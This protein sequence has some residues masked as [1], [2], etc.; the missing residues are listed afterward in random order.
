MLLS[1]VQ[2]SSFVLSATAKKSDNR[3]VLP[4]SHVKITFFAVPTPTFA[5]VKL[6]KQL[7]LKV[8]MGT[9]ILPT[10]V[11]SSF[12]SLEASTDCLENDCQSSHPSLSQLKVISI[13]FIRTSGL[14]VAL[15][16]FLI[17]FIVITTPKTESSVKNAITELIMS[18]TDILSMIPPFTF[19][20][21]LPEAVFL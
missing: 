10:I 17:S 2:K 4:S 21:S 18:P 12:S 14:Y 7:P 9:R 11:P 20:A 19:S 15:R 8:T 13:G 3:F 16:S 1:I 6:L 5:A